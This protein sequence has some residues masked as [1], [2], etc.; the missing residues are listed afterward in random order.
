[1]V[2]GKQCA[3]SYLMIQRCRFVCCFVARILDIRDNLGL[4]GARSGYWSRRVSH[5][6]FP[7][8]MLAG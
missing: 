2:P 4:C 3:V 5:A 8:E 1:M 6:G 7:C